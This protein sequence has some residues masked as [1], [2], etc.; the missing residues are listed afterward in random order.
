MGPLYCHRTTSRPGQHT[1]GNGSGTGAIRT[2]YKS[3]KSQ[4]STR[5]S[6]RSHL[7]HGHS[8]VGQGGCGRTADRV[9]RPGAPLDGT[10]APSPG[11]RSGATPPA[12]V[13]P[14]GKPPRSHETFLGRHHTPLRA[15]RRRVLIRSAPAPQPHSATM[16]ESRPIAIANLT[17]HLNSAPRPREPPELPCGIPSP[18]HPIGLPEPQKPP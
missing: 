1:G 18:S 2:L 17:R 13:A 15:T 4:E 16:R 11:P 9:N 7:N 5:G 3:S 8:D 6:T 10:K 14:Y 12:R